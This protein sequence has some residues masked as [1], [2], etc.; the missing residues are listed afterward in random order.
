M[1]E[2]IQGEFAKF[3]K[4]EDS[5][6]KGIVAVSGDPDLES[7]I[8]EYLNIKFKP[9]PLH[10][11][12]QVLSFMQWC[13]KAKESEG[14]L[15][16]IYR[17]DPFNDA[18]GEWQ[19]ACPRQWN[20]YV[21]V[22]AHAELN[23][24]WFIDAIGDVHSHPGMNW[25]GHSGTDDHDEKQHNHGIYVVVSCEH[26]KNFTVKDT[27][28]TIYAYARGRKFTIDLKDFVDLKGNPGNGKFPEEWKDR[29]KSMMGCEV[30]GY[31]MVRVWDHER[32]RHRYKYVKNP[33]YNFFSKDKF[34]SQKD[35]ISF[36]EE[37]ED[38]E[39]ESN[40]TKI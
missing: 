35:D 40:E 39:D 10:L 20:S 2:I 33:R 13:W 21:R 6:F 8:K 11:Y 1:G 31:D 37:F 19:L 25:S 30:C 14:M 7:N 18:E 32:N 22:C 38:D 16:F 15:Y 29:V 27:E 28:T 23:P 12:T 26:D 36:L 3:E 9:I 17:Q 5:L 34:F 4:Y 24:E